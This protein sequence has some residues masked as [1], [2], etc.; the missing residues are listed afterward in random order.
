MARCTWYNIMWPAR[1]RWLSPETPISSTNKTDRN[2]IS[3]ILLKVALITKNQTNPI[4][5]IILFLFEYLL[6]S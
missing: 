1:N 5:K 6:D 2:D 4:I 3:E